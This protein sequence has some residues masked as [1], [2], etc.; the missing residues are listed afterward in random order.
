[1]RGGSSME[2]ENAASVPL[3]FIL[4]L[5]NPDTVTGF[6]L[7][8]FPTREARLKFIRLSQYLDMLPSFQACF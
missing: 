5:K 8:I 7:L 2:K 4:N 6:K 1:M 3:N